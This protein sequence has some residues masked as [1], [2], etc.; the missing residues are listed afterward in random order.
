MRNYLFNWLHR[1]GMLRYFRVPAG[2]VPV[3]CFHR[4]HPTYDALTQPLHPKEF[5][6]MILGLKRHFE[7]VGLPEVLAGNVRL[8]RVLCIT[9]D[10]ALEDFYTHA[11][12]VLEELR[13]PV[14]QF[15]PT[16][17]VAQ[18]EELYNYALAGVLLQAEKESRALRVPELG[19]LRTNLA[20]Y[21]RAAH[22]LATCEDRDALL[23]GWAEMLSEKPQPMTPPMSWK[24][25][26]SL[27]NAGVQLECHSH[28]HAWLPGLSDGHLQADLQTS[29]DLMQAHLGNLPSLLAYPMGGYDGRV[30]QVAN[31]HGLMGLGTEGIV[32]CPTRGGT[33]PRFNVSDRTW[34]EVAFR[35][36]GL[37][38]RFRRKG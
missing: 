2:M 25:L 27:Q 19:T 14:M 24:Q 9:F 3:L 23:K 28:A 6:N 8:S 16:Q 4:V 17:S 29:I 1:F 31:T 20:D 22:Y 21:L 33:I 38:G 13:V 7:L 35:V 32:W 26:K 15:V 37:H 36:A 12:P 10:D 30:A 34:Q 5:K 18:G 11:F